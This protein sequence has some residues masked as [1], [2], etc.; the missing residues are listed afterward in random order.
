MGAALLAAFVS[1]AAAAADDLSVTGVVTF[2]RGG[3][4][5]FF[6]ATPSAAVWRVQREAKSEAKRS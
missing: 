5:Y 3:D 6:L 1:F 4:D 2:Q